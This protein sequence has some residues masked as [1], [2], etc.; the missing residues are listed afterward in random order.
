MTN[1]IIAFKW[2]PDFAQGYANHGS[3]TMKT[4]RNEILAVCHRLGRALHDKDV[5][6]VLACYADDA[7]IYDLAPP[8]GRRGMGREGLAAWLATWDGPIRIDAQDVDLAVDG[9]LAYTSALNRMR[10]TK[11]DGTAVDLWFRTTM[12]FARP[13]GCWRIVHDHASVPFHMDGSF[14]AAVE[15]TPPNT[16][17]GRTAA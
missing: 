14:R 7:R 4:A 11:T 17:D 13:D 15:I 9:N 12:V 8:L 10:G 1:E 16:E 2:V 5:E 6:A 3:S